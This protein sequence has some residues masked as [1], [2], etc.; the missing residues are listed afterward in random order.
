MSESELKPITER[1]EELKKEGKENKDIVNILYEEGYNTRSIMMQ[2]FSLRSLKTKTSVDDEEVQSVIAGSPGKGSGYLSEWKELVRRQMSQSRQL[3]EVFYDL[4][5][6]VLLASLSKSALTTDEYR[7][8]FAEPG[9]LREALMGASQ[10]AFK[11]LEYYKAD[12]MKALEKERDD[13]RSYA[14]LLESE[15]AKIAKSLDEALDPKLRLEK[16]IYNL[17]LMSGTSPVDPNAIATLLDKWL[18]IEIS[19]P[20]V[21][22]AIRNIST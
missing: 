13:A 4:G 3:T 1:I 20:T 10:T 19:L 9:K 2:G 14:S 21:S 22:E 6:S 8:I 7:Q 12:A 17:V 18:A 11:A 5:L 16:M 15:F